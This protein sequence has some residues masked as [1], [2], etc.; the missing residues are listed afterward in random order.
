MFT[1]RKICKVPENWR[2]EP[3]RKKFELFEVALATEFGL[4]TVRYPDLQM[5][6]TKCQTPVNY[7]IVKKSK[8][9]VKRLQP[10]K[11][12]ALPRV[13]RSITEFCGLNRQKL[14]EKLEE[15]VQKEIIEISS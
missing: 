15:M 1:A 4:F 14:Y 6:C 7:K 2:G 5:V 11:T 10:Q 3:C 8:K 13:I 9:V 12:T